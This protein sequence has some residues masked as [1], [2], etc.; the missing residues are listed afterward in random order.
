M[1]MM[2]AS[3]SESSG[4]DTSSKAEGDSVDVM[5]CDDSVL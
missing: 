4:D 3:V 1:M 2:I 5:Y